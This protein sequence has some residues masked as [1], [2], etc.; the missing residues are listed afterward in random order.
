MV[1][2]SFTFPPIVLPCRL[3]SC[4]SCFT[5][6][7]F[8]GPVCCVRSTFPFPFCFSKSVLSHLWVA[9]PTRFSVVNATGGA[10][11]CSASPWHP[12]QVDELQ[13]GSCTGEGG[14][15]ATAA[16]RS[17]ARNKIIYNW[18]YDYL[19]IL[20][21]IRN[22]RNYYYSNYVLFATI[23]IDSVHF[24]SSYYHHFHDAYYCYIFWSSW[25]LLWYHYYVSLLGGTTTR[26][27]RT[28]DKHKGKSNGNTF[29][30]KKK[31]TQANS[32]HRPT[33]SL[34]HTVSL[35]SY[36]LALRMFSFRAKLIVA[37]GEFSLWSL[38]GMAYVF[39]RCQEPS[40]LVKRRE[41]RTKEEEEKKDADDFTIS[42]CSMKVLVKLI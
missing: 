24:H 5:S 8:S 38:L 10:F 9:S 12:A 33:P 11:H 2:L 40:V 4:W 6:C 20:Y 28:S 21:I 3:C 27:I 23:I 34:A 39:H 41:N 15:L 26:R 30:D 7:R 32:R 35:S 1:L 31:N 18:L 16:T 25:L 13:G 14:I 42:M 37:H 29:N 17:A 19:I 22:I 36:T